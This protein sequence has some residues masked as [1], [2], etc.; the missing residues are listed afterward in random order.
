MSEE[1]KMTLF[2]QPVGRG[3]VPFG[4]IGRPKGLKGEVFVSL[5]HPETDLLEENLSVAV[6]EKTADRELKIG[7]VRFHN[8]KTIL[9]FE[10][11]K[12]ISDVEGFKNWTLFVRRMDFKATKPN[13]YYHVDLIG[14]D[15][16]D[17]A[18]HFLGE[19]VS[20]LPA[21]SND[22]FVVKKVEVETLIP[23]LPGVLVRVDMD[24]EKIILNPLKEDHAV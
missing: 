18:M 6:G 13:Q 22:I 5:Y 15:V 10:G 20:I 1:P 24:G 21:P 7:S 19:L 4:K 16:F 11:L 3:W 17:E 23:I 8:Q 2:H 9:S 12:N 14:L